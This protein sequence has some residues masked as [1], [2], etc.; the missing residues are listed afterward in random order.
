[1]ADREG[2]ADVATV[3]RSLAAAERTHC[4]RWLDQLA[5]LSDPLTAEPIGDTF[6]NLHAAITAELHDQKDMCELELP[7]S[8]FF[9]LVVISKD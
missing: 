7:V 8:V 2:Y 5:T 6:S 1:M 9:L 4:L 3:F